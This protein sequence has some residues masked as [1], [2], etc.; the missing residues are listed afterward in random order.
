MAMLP[1]HHPIT[2][3]KKTLVRITS[4]RSS[5]TTEILIGL[6][7]EQQ[8]TPHKDRS[9]GAQT[10]NVLNATILVGNTICKTIT[11]GLQ[12]STYNDKKRA[13]KVPPCKKTTDFGPFNGCVQHR[14][15]TRHSMVGPT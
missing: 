2:D 4:T 5:R 15:H 9:T 8:E 12:P 14:C 7:Q 10:D 6:A 1:P 3:L 13:E 11:S